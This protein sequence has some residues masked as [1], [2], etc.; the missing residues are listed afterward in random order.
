MTPNDLE[1]DHMTTSGSGEGTRPLRIV[2]VSPP[3]CLLRVPGVFEALLG[4]GIE[5]VF[6]VKGNDKP[7][8]PEPILAHPRVSITRLPLRRDDQARGVDVFRTIGDLARYLEPDMLDAGNSRVEVARRLLKLLHHPDYDTLS[9]QAAGIA[10]PSAVAE[11]LCDAFRSFERSLPPPPGLSEAI[12]ELRPDAVLML[13]R[14]TF[15]G[16]EPDVIKSTR[17]LGIPSV[18]LVWSWDNLSSKAVLHEHPDWLLVWND[19]QAAEA[20]DLHDVPPERVKVV[21]AANFDRFFE[22]VRLCIAS[23]SSGVTGHRRR[24]LYLASSPHV[25]RDEPAIFE[26]WL[27]AVRTSPDADV[28][29]AAVTIRSYPGTSAWNAWRP[30]QDDVELVPGAK[31]GGGLARMLADADAVVALNTSAEIE[32][33]IAG[34]PVVT[35]RPGSGDAPGQEGSL[36]FKYLLESQG[37]FVIDSPTLDDHVRMLGAVLRGEFDG[38]AMSRFV[39][40]FVRPCGVEEPVAP[41]IAASVIELTRCSSSNGR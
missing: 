15:G 11:S 7:R 41:R 27:D 14:L 24:V 39:E 5:L 2:V 8:L 30:A 28:R 16:V 19:V 17:A 12:G 6:A 38:A 22:D 25:A 20:A 26:R 33:A 23:G 40:R 1:L 4:A 35:F 37:G 34:R 21:G 10:A 36:H 31:N 32:A 9:P 29:G 13:S 3:G 18:M